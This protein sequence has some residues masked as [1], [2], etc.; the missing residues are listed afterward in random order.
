MR[1][2]RRFSAE[3]LL[4]ARLVAGWSRAELPERVGVTEATVK[5]WEIGARAP[6]A[7]TQRRL[8]AALGLG[9]DGLEQPGPADAEDLRRLRV[10]LG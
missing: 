1:R 3:A 8:A 2:N 4:D 5:A 9:F 7:S 6:K 10:S